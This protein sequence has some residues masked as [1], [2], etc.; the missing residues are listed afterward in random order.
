MS[1]ED[2]Q[3][4]VQTAWKEHGL[5]NTQTATEQEVQLLCSNVLSKLGGLELSGTKFK[6]YYGDME[7]NANGG[8]TKEEF[9]KLI[10]TI[11]N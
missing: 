6:A 11:V 5:D 3:T 2:I 8:V 10:A 1:P 4:A 7:K 9:Q